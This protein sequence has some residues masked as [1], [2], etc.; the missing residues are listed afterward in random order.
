MGTYCYLQS[1]KNFFFFFLLEALIFNSMLVWLF[2]TQLEG[3]SAADLNL[4]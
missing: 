2:T 4:G 1:Y 3:H